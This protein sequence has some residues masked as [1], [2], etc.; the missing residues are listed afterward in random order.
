MTRSKSLATGFLSFSAAA[1]LAFSAAGGA[2]AAPVV[3]GDKDLL[4]VVGAV[5][6]SAGAAEYWTDERM[7]SAIP[8]EVLAAEAVERGNR[9]SRVTAAKGGGSE[10]KVQPTSGKLAAE[11]DTESHIGKI[12]FTLG[13]QNFVCS[14]NAVSSGNESTV[15]TAGHCLN[16][17]P[18]TKPSFF[19]FVPGYEDGERPYGTWVAKSYYV[20]ALWNARGDMAFDTGFAVVEK[21]NGQTLTDVVGGSGAVFNQAKGLKYEAFGYP[22]AKPSNGERLQSCKGTAAGD[23]RNPQFN[24]QGIRCDMNGGSSGG[25]WLIKD[26]AEE[27]IGF[28][29]SVNS[30]GYPGLD[31]MYGPYWGKEIQ[32]TYNLASMS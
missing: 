25:P 8:G 21:L 14:G 19:I 27:S 18:G 15:A 6:D 23:P 32:L 3:S 17:G 2:S 7:R 11:T 20:P 24:S 16:N 1:V 22:V 29:N 5:L 9:S 12:F 31:I 10:T 13:G 4:P 30:Y 26:G 28:Q